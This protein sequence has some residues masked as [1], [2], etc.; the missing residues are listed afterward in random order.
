MSA[1]DWTGPDDGDPENTWVGTSEEDSDEDNE[2]DANLSGGA[3]ES[4]PP[5]EPDGG[6]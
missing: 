4:D 3:E 6:K 5:D 2:D 1:F